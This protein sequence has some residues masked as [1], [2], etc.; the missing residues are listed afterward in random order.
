MPDPFKSE[1]KPIKP[2]PVPDLPFLNLTQLRELGERMKRA[3]QGTC[4]CLA[5]REKMEIIEAS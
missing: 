5:C 3:P 2:I 1:D 4:Q